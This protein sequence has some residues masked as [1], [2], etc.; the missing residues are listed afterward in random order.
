MKHGHCLQYI[1]IMGVSRTGNTAVYS[2]FM[3]DLWGCGVLG[4]EHHILFFTFLFPSSSSFSLSC[5]VR[6]TLMTVMTMPAGRYDYD[7][8]WD[9]KMISLCDMDNMYVVNELLYVPWMNGMRVF[10][11]LFISIY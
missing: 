10:A 9:E 7:G 11:I 8:V 4:W 3:V 6:H 5:L 2:C 1:E